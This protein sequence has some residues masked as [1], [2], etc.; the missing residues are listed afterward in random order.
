MINQLAGA[1]NFRPVRMKKT[2]SCQLRVM[3]TYDHIKR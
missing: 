2:E 1:T 3:M